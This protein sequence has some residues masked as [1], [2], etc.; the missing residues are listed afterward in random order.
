MEKKKQAKEQG[1]IELEEYYD[2][3]NMRKPHLLRCGRFL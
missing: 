1:K 2:L 3:K